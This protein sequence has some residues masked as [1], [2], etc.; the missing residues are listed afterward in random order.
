MLN[1]QKEI[2]AN[3]HCKEW[4]YEKEYESPEMVID[5]SNISS[6]VCAKESG[7]GWEEEDDLFGYG[8]GDNKGEE[9]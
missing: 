1:R 4:K 9:I 2:T 7:L 3:L 8:F 5:Y 6:S